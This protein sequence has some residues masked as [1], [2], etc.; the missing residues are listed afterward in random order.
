[1]IRT[2]V[3]KELNCILKK[4]ANFHKVLEVEGT[5]IWSLILRHLKGTEVAL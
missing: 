5:L 1:M 3:V 4:E 2:S